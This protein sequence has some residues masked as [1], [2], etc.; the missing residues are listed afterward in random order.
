MALSNVFI[1]NSQMQSGT[2]WIENCLM[3]LGIQVDEEPKVLFKYKGRYSNTH[4]EYSLLPSAEASKPAIPILMFKDKFIF[5]NDIFGL[6]R[7][8][9]FPETTFHKITKTII[10]VRDPRDTMWSQYKFDPMGMDFAHWLEVNNRLK[11]WIQF[12]ESHLKLTDIA[13]FKFE[14]YKKDPV[15]HLKNI[16]KFINFNASDQEIELA[17]MNSSMEKTQEGEKL[18]RQMTPEEKRPHGDKIR[19]RAGAVKQ[20]RDQPEN[21]ATFKFIEEQT[22][23]LM[24]IFGYE[25]EFI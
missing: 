25:C 2:S 18:Y 5:L 21:L 7:A 8:H 10:A 4:S 13:F 17:V 3:E 11:M 9:N 19:N 24:K 6:F 20:W 23:H 14:D 1:V 15:N 22:A 16:L 12:H